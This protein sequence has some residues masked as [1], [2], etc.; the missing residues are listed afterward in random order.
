VTFLRCGG[1]VFGTAVHHAVVDGSS[2]FHFT[3]TWGS[4]CRDG[5]GAV[6]EPLPCHDRAVLRARSPP[7]I[8]PARDHPDILQQPD[9]ADIRPRDRGL[10]HLR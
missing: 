10:H 6:V 3:R 9:H 5:K 8:H 4:Y 1:A 7:V 2:M